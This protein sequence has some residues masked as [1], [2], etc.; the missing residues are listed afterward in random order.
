[1]NRFDRIDDENLFTGEPLPPP[2]PPP[3]VH[4]IWELGQELPS[5]PREWLFAAFVSE[6]PHMN[7]IV[8]TPVA[9][10]LQQRAQI[11]QHVGEAIYSSLPHYMRDQE[12]MEATFVVPDRHTLNDIR[13]DLTRAGFQTD[14]AFTSFIREAAPQGL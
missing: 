13:T 9:Y 6:E 4:P 10:W 11:D 14:M 5:H 12:E 7:C 2:E 1:M 3:V 8:F